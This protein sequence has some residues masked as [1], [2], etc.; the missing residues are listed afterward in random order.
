[1]KAINQ[2]SAKL[3]VNHSLVCSLSDTR[4]FNKDNSSSWTTTIITR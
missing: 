2:V 3:S 4:N 1:M